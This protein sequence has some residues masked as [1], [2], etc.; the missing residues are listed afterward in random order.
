LLASAVIDYIA[1]KKDIAPVVD[2]RIKLKM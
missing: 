1:A 2:G